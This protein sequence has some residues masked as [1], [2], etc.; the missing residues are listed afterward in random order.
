MNAPATLTLPL[1]PI[2]RRRIEDTIEQLLALLDEAD[3]DA[4]L[5]PDN[6]DE[7]SFGWTSR[8]DGVPVS[9]AAE[10]GDDRELE[11]EHDED[12]GDA[13]WS[14]QEAEAGGLDFRGDG[15]EIARAMLGAAWRQRAGRD[16]RA[17][18]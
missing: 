6:D 8:F 14:D 4:D 3:G 10:A 17:A 18:S 13:E 1:T 16:A 2:A 15:E 9:P 7:P 11:D 12:G 5:E